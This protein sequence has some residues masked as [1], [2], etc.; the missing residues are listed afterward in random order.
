MLSRLTTYFQQCIS[1]DCRA[2]FDLD[3]RLYVCSRCGGLLDIERREEIHSAPLPDLWLKRR[4]SLDARDRS[5]VWRFREY[6]PFTED[7]EVVSLGE[8]NTPLYDA[9]RAA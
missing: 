2:E 7:T 8:G 4:S 9:P 5:G 6:L 3:A 1:P